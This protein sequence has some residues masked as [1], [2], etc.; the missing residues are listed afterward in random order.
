MLHG[1][2]AWFGIGNEG[3]R[4]KMKVDC[5]MGFY[6]ARANLSPSLA[7]GADLSPALSEGEGEV[8]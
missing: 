4:V 7:E 6:A 3:V 1:I 5:C 2:F 8:E